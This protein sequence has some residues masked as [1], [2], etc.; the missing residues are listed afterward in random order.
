MRNILLVVVIVLVIDFSFANIPSPGWKEGPSQESDAPRQ[1]R[2]AA[3]GMPGGDV[4][5]MMAMAQKIV[6]MA[7]GKASNGN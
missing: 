3:F 4:G 1:K 7:K 2:H 5:G 6:S